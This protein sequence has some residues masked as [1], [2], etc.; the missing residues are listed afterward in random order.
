[1]GMQFDMCTS[2][3]EA[4]SNIAHDFC[5][6]KTVWIGRS[7]QQWRSFVHLFVRIRVDGIDEVTRI[8]QFW[9]Y[10]H[11][12]YTHP[13]PIKRLSKWPECGS[14]ARTPAG[15]ARKPFLPNWWKRW[16]A[17]HRGSTQLQFKVEVRT[18]F[19][20]WTSRYRQSS[21]RRLRPAFH[22]LQTRPRRDRRISDLR[23]RCWHWTA[24]TLRSA[25]WQ[26]SRFAEFEI[27]FDASL[28]SF[29]RAKSSPW[30]SPDIRKA[31]AA[32]PT[33]KEPLSK[34]RLMTYPNRCSGLP[35]WLP[36]A[37]TKSLLW[38]ETPANA[39]IICGSSTQSPR[40]WTSIIELFSKHIV[41]LGVSNRNTVLHL[42][43]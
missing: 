29:S 21:Q 25:R 23:L 17:L 4:R 30:A 6:V 32:G 40:P 20:S 22:R 13:C 16:S 28:I 38:A 1:M 12:Y 5:R 33:T 42:V 9:K 26:V 3:I 15:A 36:Q 43:P 41:G 37:P 24:R 14:R 8:R 34:T 11:Q 10:C 2:W 35:L 27:F 19:E 39:S 7:R 31:V 18:T